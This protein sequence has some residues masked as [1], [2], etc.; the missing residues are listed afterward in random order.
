MTAQTLL[1]RDNKRP[2]GLR[3]RL[4][5][6]YRCAVEIRPESP[7]FLGE[8]FAQLRFLLSGQVRLDQLRVALDR[9]L[10]PSDA[11]LSRTALVLIKNSA[12]VPA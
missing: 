4:A 6:R 3:A 8:N 11:T 12:E 2:G 9:A 10:H 1:N 5:L 7:A